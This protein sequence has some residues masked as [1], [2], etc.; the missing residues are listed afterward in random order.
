MYIKQL[1]VL[2]AS[3]GR[4]EELADAV[5]CVTGLFYLQVATNQLGGLRIQT[6]SLIQ[7]GT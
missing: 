3:D 6:D 1:G 2:F 5:D 4:G 7:C